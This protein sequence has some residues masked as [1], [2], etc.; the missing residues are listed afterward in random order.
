MGWTALGGHW[1]GW[2]SL[3]MDGSHFLTGEHSHASKQVDA[4]VVGI[5]IFATHVLF[6]G[7]LFR[8]TYLQLTSS[9]PLHPSTICITS[10]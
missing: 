10:T 8:G 2:Y 9:H 1:S 5:R 6:L 4:F 3:G 7:H